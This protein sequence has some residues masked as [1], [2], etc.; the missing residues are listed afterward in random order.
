MFQKQMGQSLF[1]TVVNLKGNPRACVFTE[2]LWGISLNIV[3]PYTSVYMLAIGLNDIQVGLIATVYMASQVVFA[4]FGGPITDKLGRRK[5]TAIFDFTAWCV[6]CLIWWQA[7]NFWFFFFAA[8]INGTMQVVV[9][10]WNCLLVEDA[11]KSEI[12]GIH[13]LIVIAVQISAFFGP[14]AVIMFSKLTL[15]PAMR[16]LYIYA[17]L[18]MSFKIFLTYYFSRETAMG[19]IRQEETKGKSIFTLAAGYGGVLKI[20]LGSHGTIFA[21]ILTAIHGIVVMINNTFWQIIVSR[22]LLV[23]VHILPL[24]PLLRAVITIFFLFF[25]VP[26]MTQGKLKFPLVTGFACFFIGQLILILTPVSGAI[27][28]VLLC[29][30]LL[31]DGFGY[32]TVQMLTKSLVTLNVNPGERAR[33][34]AILHMIIMAVTAPFGWIGGLL[35][36]MSRSFPFILN[37]V[38]LMA[39][40]LITLAY[41][42]KRPAD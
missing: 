2:P 36:D 35:S 7:G 28:Y 27:T 39:G 20:I 24:F 37:I 34:M 29:V 12:T 9:N 17:F 25:V 38:L 21:M 26:N 31:L 40:L 13:S 18:M 22:K 23:P 32:G 15:V 14:I 30:S 10:G 19:L 42:R 3:I 16:I 6:P 1:K 41:Y 33:V 11:D 5:T 8:I 4:F